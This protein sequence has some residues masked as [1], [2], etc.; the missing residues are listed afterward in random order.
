MNVLKQ[1]A[2]VGGEDSSPTY[3]AVQI[4][5]RCEDSA[6]QFIHDVLKLD[7]VKGGGGLVVRRQLPTS[8]FPETVFHVTCSNTHLLMLAE[9]MEIKKEDLEGHIRPVTLDEI[10]QFPE[11]GRVGPLDISDIHR[12]VQY[13]MERIHF[14]MSIQSLPGHPGRSV[15]KGAPV[16][17]SYQERHLVSVFPV[18]DSEDLDKLNKSWSRSPLN[19]PLDQ[20]RSYFGESVT[21]Y[22]SFTESYT[23]FLIL[24]AILG[25]IE[26]LCETFGI[27]YVYSNVLFSFFNLLCLGFFLELWKRKANEHSFFWGTS[28]KLRLKPP[29]PEYRGELRSNPVTGKQEMYYSKGKRLKK[30]FFVSFPLTFLCLA[31]AFGLMIGSFEGDRIMAL[32]L[33]DPDTEEVSTDFLSK[34]LINVPSILYSLSIIIFNKVYLK[35]ARSLTTWENHRTQEQHDTHITIKLVTFEFVNTFLA[36]FYMGFWM[37]DIAGL[38]GQLFT[39]LIVQ[40]VVNQV[41]EVLIPLVLHK[42]ASQKFF[43]KMSKKLGVNEE[44]QKRKLTGTSDLTNDDDRVRAVSHDILA[45]PLDTLHDDFMEIWLQFGHVFLF[46]AVY[47]LAA[48]IALVN[49][50]T[51][52]FADRYK[53][54]SL[55][56]KPRP[57]AVRDIG[58]WYMAFRITA[59]I[60]IISNCGL[61]ALDLRNTAGQD[62]SSVEWFGMFVLIEHVF[63]VA[64]IGINK[65]VSD[66]SSQ[67]KLAMDKTEYHFKQKHVKDDK[68]K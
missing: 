10:D 64:F 31:M 52:L 16:I 41:Q 50:L 66:T 62:W 15:L 55:S 59:I 2:C 44:P 20:I 48:V 65:L 58:A 29:R 17:S 35:M 61:I 8:A 68:D 11:S 22:W 5:W 49:N 12:C 19:P 56:R 54:C 46:S 36:L 1:F 18:H 37:Q 34:I 40:Q 32:L 30:I 63:L 28:G 39:T 53:L 33:T 42:P 14:D 9:L 4:H 27:N 43:H 60:S 13:A 38:R 67:V 21:L 23:K 26:Y 6:A 57:L 47:P 7:W 25:L 3:Y 51:E 45:D 24:I